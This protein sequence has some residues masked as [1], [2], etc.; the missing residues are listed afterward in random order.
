VETC[1]TCHG[2]GQVRMQ[3][4]FFSVQQTCGTCRGQ[5]KIIKNPCHACHGS[6]VADRQQT[7]EVTIPAG[8]DNGDRVR[9]SGKGE[10]IR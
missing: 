8:V 1:K 5:G 2:S 9:L 3:Q 7:L 4:G 6:G 10:A